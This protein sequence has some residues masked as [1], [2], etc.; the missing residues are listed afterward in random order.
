MPSTPES[1]DL[2]AEPPFVGAMLRLAWQRARARIQVA[3][4]DAGFTDLQDAHL[5]VFSYPPPD[6]VRPSDLA[7]RIGMSRQAANH[8]ITQMEALG[9]LERRAKEEGAR[10]LVHLTPRGRDVYEVIF[11]CMRDLQQDWA[12]EIGPRRF[13]EFLA[14]LRQLAAA[15]P[16]A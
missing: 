2:P 11:A 6:G 8:V 7:R 5:P 16:S 3:I 9:Y 1:P 14:V 13:A 10:R 4:R 15:Q 12:A